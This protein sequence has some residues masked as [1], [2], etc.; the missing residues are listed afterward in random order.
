M[1]DE[2]LTQIIT[3]AIFLFSFYSGFNTG[4]KK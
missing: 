1:I 4:V 3:A 2:H